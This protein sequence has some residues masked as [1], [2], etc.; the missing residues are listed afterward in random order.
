[1]QKVKIIIDSKHEKDSIC[2]I[3][4]I[5]KDGIERKH[6]LFL[7]KKSKLSLINLDRRE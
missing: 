5:D 6:V 1:M 3:V 4:L 2:E 7:S